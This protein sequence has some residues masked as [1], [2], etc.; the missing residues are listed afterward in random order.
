MGHSGSCPF[1]GT[2]EAEVRVSHE[3]WL[4]HASRTDDERQFMARI[5]HGKPE[6]KFGDILRCPGCGLIYVERIPGPDALTGF[7]QQYYANRNYSGKKD[8]KI[9]RNTRHLARLRRRMRRQPRS[10]ID[11]GCNVGYAVVAAHGLGLEATGIEI[12]G[13]A[14]DLAQAEFPDC[15]FICDDV[16]SF[17]STGRTFDIV[18]C[19]EVLEHVSD[20][21]SF[22]S[23]LGRL[24]SANGVLFL[25]TPDAGHWRVPN[26]LKEWS[27]I[28]PPEHIVWFS[29]R[30]LREMFEPMAS[31]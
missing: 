23:A 19:S 24:V 4:E 20:F 26:D 29:K 1:C 13:E 6:L 8:K 3:A 25:T 21:K 2:A 14:V 15:E 18:H 31:G 30:H 5:V 22:A 10:F 12:D 11:V 16:M 27:E 17:A 9:K 28:K 7:Y